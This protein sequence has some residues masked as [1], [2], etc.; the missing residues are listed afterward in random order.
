MSKLFGITG[1]VFPC[2]QGSERISILLA[3]LAFL[4]VVVHG[5]GP[6]LSAFGPKLDPIFDCRC[7]VVAGE[8]TTW[9]LR[10]FFLRPLIYSNRMV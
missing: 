9:V 4:Y 8:P 6:S 10:R 1:A 5:F 7:L 2:A 3:R